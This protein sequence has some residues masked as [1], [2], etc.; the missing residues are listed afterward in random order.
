MAFCGQ[1]L[2]SFWTTDLAGLVIEGYQPLPVK[3]CEMLS[4]ADFGDAEGA[5]EGARAQRTARLQR[6]ED[7]VAVV[8]AHVMPRRDGR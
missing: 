7:P 3:L 4:H 8:G 1:P 5:S 6:I 2:L